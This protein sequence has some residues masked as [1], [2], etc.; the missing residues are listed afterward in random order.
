MAKWKNDPNNYKKLKCLQERV[1]HRHR[2]YEIHLTDYLHAFV[3][4]MHHKLFAKFIHYFKA[5]YKT[6]T[7]TFWVPK[8]CRYF[9]VKV[10]DNTALKVK[11]DCVVFLNVS[12][13]ELGAGFLKYGK[14]YNECRRGITV[15]Q[16]KMDFKLV[17]FSLD[18]HQWLGAAIEYWWNKENNVE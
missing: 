5:T 6:E 14:P 15:K 3:E 11:H 7:L 4:P 12:H 10:G 17:G 9:L 2:Y 8:S 1:I 16:A 18:T 13:T